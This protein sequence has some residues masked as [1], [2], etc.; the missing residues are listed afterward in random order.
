MNGRGAHNFTLVGGGNF[1][2]IKRFE[3]KPE[4]SE[5]ESNGSNCRKSTPRRG[6]AS[7]NLLKKEY[8]TAEGPCDWSRYSV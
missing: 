1:T 2:A 5:K 7:V 4:R 8:V 6:P 3:E